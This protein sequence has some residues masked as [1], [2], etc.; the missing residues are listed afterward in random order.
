LA[1]R[2]WQLREAD[3]DEPFGGGDALG[4]NPDLQT[5]VSGGD[6]RD[7]AIFFALL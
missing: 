7:R 6:I 2:R 1:A 3:L 4:P 5:G